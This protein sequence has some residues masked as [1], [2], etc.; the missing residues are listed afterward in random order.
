M[1]RKTIR[2]TITVTKNGFVRGQQQS[3]TIARHSLWAVAALGL[4]VLVTL[5]QFGDNGVFAL[6]QLRGHEAELRHEVLELQQQRTELNERL[7][8]L[9]GDDQE[10]LEKLAREKYNMQRAGETVL[11]VIPRAKN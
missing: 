5:V 4:L 1:K 7:A 8:A 3:S 9:T 2:K 10:V 11:V 6:I